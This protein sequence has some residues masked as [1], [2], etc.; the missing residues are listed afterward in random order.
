MPDFHK[1][2]VCRSGLG[3]ADA[4][5]LVR[6]KP[7]RVSRGPVSF[8]GAVHFWIRPG[9]FFSYSKRRQST[10]GTTHDVLLVLYKYPAALPPLQLQTYKRAGS[11][12]EVHR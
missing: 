2:R 1:P 4:W 12:F 9:L 8:E 11:A 5:D 3:R 6:C 7:S 10:A